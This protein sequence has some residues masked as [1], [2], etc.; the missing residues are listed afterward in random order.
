M[1]TANEYKA[2]TEIASKFQNIDV[3]HPLFHTFAT[4]LGY[5]TTMLEVTDRPTL[6]RED[7]DRIS[8]LASMGLVEV[9]TTRGTKWVALTK[10]GKAEAAKHGIEL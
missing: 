5:A 6:R 8:T 4:F 9:K 7:E 1:F 2:R 10:A 3:H